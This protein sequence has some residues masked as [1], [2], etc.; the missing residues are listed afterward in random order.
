MQ[1]LRNT[2]LVAY[3]NRKNNTTATTS[4]TVTTT[5]ATTTTATNSTFTTFSCVPFLFKYSKQNIT[6]HNVRLNINIC[7]SWT[8]LKS[9]QWKIPSFIVHRKHKLILHKKWMNGSKDKRKSNKTNR[10]IGRVSGS[11]WESEQSSSNKPQKRR[12]IF[13]DRLSGQS[14]QIS[15]QPA[16]TSPSLTETLGQELIWNDYSIKSIVKR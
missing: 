14:E 13:T 7:E 16:N 11:I 9:N 1:S 12:I 10:V 5:S 15:D 3:F 6:L 8:Y 4:T 2:R